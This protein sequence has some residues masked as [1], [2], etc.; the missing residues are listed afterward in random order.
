M[1]MAYTKKK[2][3]NSSLPG[4]GMVFVTKAQRLGNFDSTNCSVN[5]YFVK[6]GQGISPL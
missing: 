6:P 3:R 4:I 2:Y 5:S 1:G